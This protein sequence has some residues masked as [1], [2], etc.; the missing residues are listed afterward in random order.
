MSVHG[1]MLRVLSL[2]AL[3][4]SM[5][6]AL[7]GQ[8][9]HAQNLFLQ[10]NQVTP[11]AAV[12]PTQK[13][14]RGYITVNAE[15]AIGG[16]KVI[17]EVFQ[18][19]LNSP[20]KLSLGVAV[21]SPTAV[22]GQRAGTLQM[23]IKLL[24]NGISDP[25]FFYQKEEFF[26]SYDE[27]QKI[28]SVDGTNPNGLKVE[29]GTA[30]V[31][32]ADFPSGHDWGGFDR[33]GVFFLPPPLDAQ[34]KPMEV[35]RTGKTA[36]NLPTARPS[37]LDLAFNIPTT[38]TNIF[39]DRKTGAGLKPGGQIRS[40]VEGEG[41]FQINQAEYLHIKKLLI[42]LSNDP[43]KAAEL[44]GPDWTI[45]FEDRYMKKD[46]AGQVIKG[47]DGLPIPDPMVDTYYDN[48]KLE[49]AKNDM[50]IRYR[51]TEGNKTGSWNF[52]PGIGRS[53]ANG[54]MYRVEFG[55]D[56]TDDKPSSI[57]AFADSF[58]PLNFWQI[59]RQVIPGATPSEF[60]KPAVRLE[61][62]RYKF[63]L[64]HKN[65]LEIEISV[66]DVR[67]FDLRKGKAPA[68]YY[69]LEMDIAH[70]ATN[71][72]NV[73]NGTAGT[74][75]NG[76]A[77]KTTSGTYSY[78]SNFGG[79]WSDTKELHD[80]VKTF[81]AA[82]GPEA[83]F[84]GRPVL[85]DAMDVAKDSSLLLSRKFDFDMSGQVIEK[86]RNY[87]MP[88]GWRPGAQKYAFAAAALGLVDVNEM[89][90]SS[91]KVKNQ[92]LAVKGQRGMGPLC[93]NMFGGK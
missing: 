90:T 66:D 76:I 32:K 40:R 57:K 37:A 92:V 69:Q 38:M 30:F 39:N 13:V 83:Q 81:L 80:A 58:H 78:Q 8:P 67:A 75:N 60:L 73:V 54:V 93:S 70:L 25:K 15:P 28:F 72:M 46:A 50:A 48:E 36:S 31:V 87:T 35:V 52:K 9:A 65:N 20:V 43:K 17:V 24:S 71:S 86:V 68:R 14:A 56:T 61:D 63:K 91:Q 74:S 18:D 42:E 59:I 27:L 10:G 45:K 88:K 82:V 79:R 77:Y 34:G 85:H 55:G 7:S 4:P 44:L 26:L 12:D 84:D 49:A 23:P 47:A 6:I 64:H 51:W 5:I 11:S 41:K 2:A 29:P 19:R 33:G 22:G 89:S 1:Q 62:N 53:D 21:N 16:A 3:A